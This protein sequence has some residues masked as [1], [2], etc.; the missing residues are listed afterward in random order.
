MVVASDGEQALRLFEAS[1]APILAVILDRTMP[2]LSG[3]E[4]LARMRKIQ[5]EL[6]AVLVSGYSEASASRNGD[7]G[8]ADAYLEK[9]FMPEALVRAVRQAIE[10]GDAACDEV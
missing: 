8:E 6:P 10:K 4:A 1:S 2:V 3:C 9:P 5:P 7:L